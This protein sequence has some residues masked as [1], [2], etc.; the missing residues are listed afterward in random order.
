MNSQEKHIWPIAVIGGGVV[1]CAIL[2]QFALNGLK[3]VLLERGQDILSGASKAN[4]ALFHSGFD[5]DPE[6][7]EYACIQRGRTEY[8]QVVAQLNLPILKT[9]ALMIGRGVGQ[10]EQIEHL[11]NSVSQNP[12]FAVSLNSE[13]EVRASFPWLTPDLLGGM[14][15]EGEDV[16]DPWS[17]AL[18]YA[19]HAI[20]NGAEIVRGCEVEDGEF[21]GHVWRLK[22]S[23]G[24]VFAKVVINAAGINADILETIRGE[25][26]FTIKPRKGQFVVFDKAASEIVNTIVLPVPTKDSKGVLIAPTIFGNVICGPTSENQES[27]TDSSVSKAVLEKLLATASDTVPELR[28]IPVTATY[29]GIRTATES[30]DYQIRGF[31]ENHWIA[32][33]GIRSTGL[34][35]ALGIANY[36]AEIYSSKFESLPGAAS[37]VSISVP[38]LAEHQTRP[39]QTG[40]FGEIVCHCERVTRLEIENAVTGSLPATDIHGLKRRTRVLMGR[41]QGFYCSSRV[42][43]LTADRINWPEN[44]PSRGQHETL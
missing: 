28:H 43:Q 32:V 13:S 29:A 41:C 1:G 3:G 6:S 31:P 20:A 44:I 25:S 19:Q 40:G 22:T 15:I 8:L 37:S 23:K 26:E 39:Y 9:S 34:T 11:H 5:A 14:L 17:T 33:A 24:D 12:N 2:R 4:S 36:V 30:K 42:F 21:D 10:M 35:A 18:A 38:N 16:I 7:L 27:R